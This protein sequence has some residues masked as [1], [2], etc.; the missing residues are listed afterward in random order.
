MF[1]FSYQLAQKTCRFLTWPPAEDGVQ[2]AG[3][4]QNIEALKID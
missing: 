1:G 3:Q 2:L 4:L